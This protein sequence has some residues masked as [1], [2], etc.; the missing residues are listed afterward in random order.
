LNAPTT[1]PNGKAIWVIQGKN[2]TVENIEFANAH[3]ADQN[4]A[5]IRQEGDG[6]IVRHCFFHDNENGILGGGGTASTVVIE[7][8]E[9]ANNGF[10]DG[11]SH[12]MYISNI[13]SFTLRYS[14]SHHARIG[15]LVK[16]RARLNYILYNSL[17]DESTGTS[18]YQIDL[19]NGGTSYVIGNAIQ[20]GPNQDNPTLISFGA[21]GLTNSGV[22]L[23]VVNNTLVNDH[24]SGTFV[25]GTTGTTTRMTNNILVGPGTVLSGAGDTTGNLVTQNPGFVNRSGY[26]YHLTSGSPAV[27][28]GKAPGSANG[29]ALSP[30]FQYQGNASA[31]ARP[32][33]GNL[34]M[35][36]FE[37][38]VGS[39]LRRGRIPRSGIVKSHLIFRADKGFL[40]LRKLDVTNGQYYNLRGISF[41][42]HMY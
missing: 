22:D 7:Y 11:Q 41:I 39:G 13:G 5:G 19:P 35:G 1:I 27:N 3:V 32:V 16:S 8:S 20:Q 23:Y 37:Y 14:H 24:S 33:V 25:R 21:E 34:D 28:I 26:D 2:T 4:G 38:G 15:H 29:F 17:M 18:S 40:V 12:N 36:A 42:A 9:F 30:D 6:L 10:G 31:I